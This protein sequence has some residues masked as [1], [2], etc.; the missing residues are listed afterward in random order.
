MKPYVPA[1]FF[2]SVSLVMSVQ[3][4]AID[5]TNKDASEDRPTAAE[6]AAIAALREAGAS[7]VQRPNGTA[8]DLHAHDVRERFTD[9]H[10][11]FVA[12]LRQLEGLGLW[13]TRVTD[14][15]LR[16]AKDLSSLRSLD[17]SDHITDRSMPLLKGFP[18]LQR[19]HFMDIAPGI[20][21]EGFKYVGQLERLENL[22]L[23]SRVTDTGIQYLQW[24]TS[25]TSLSV[26]K[27]QVTDEGLKHLAGL[28]NLRSLS[29]FAAPQMTGEGLKHL[30]GLTELSNLLL[31]TRFNDKM[32][33][34][35]VA[36]QK[37]H[38]Q[39]ITH[40][41]G[42]TDAGL[43]H[44]SRLGGVRALYLGEGVTDA[45]IKHLESM[46][47]LSLLDLRQTKA[48]DGCLDSLVR[49]TTLTSLNLPGTISHQ[50]LER[51]LVLPKLRGISVTN[52]LTDKAVPVL[53][54][55]THLNDLTLDSTGISKEGLERLREHLEPKTRLLP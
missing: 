36:F 55:F 17:L 11:P 19:L 28:T 9:A 34:Y 6:T 49:I 3:V 50:G 37:L 2:V 33:P 47:L 12:E 26:G 1:F 10:M 52:G 21:D 44:L 42:V 4:L 40:C 20:T 38:S 27:S 51:L 24:S 30:S 45:G 23:P 46:P 14:A 39:Q 41:P 43:V 15:G 22:K 7:V 54:K 13:G 48:T 16:Q 25:L 35:L 5:I 31:P 8:R 29:M 53:L 18:D 32:M